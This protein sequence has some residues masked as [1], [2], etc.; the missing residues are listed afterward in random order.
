MRS[1]Y[2]P[3]ILFAVMAVVGACTDP[4]PGLNKFT[5]PGSDAV[6]VIPD[7]G[8]DAGTADAA[9]TDKLSLLG[10]KPTHGPFVGGTTVT[11]R[12]TG[13]K[14]TCKVQIGGKN[15]QVGQTKVLSPLSLAVVS[16]PGIPGPAEVSITC[17]SDKARILN[18]YSYDSV[19]MDPSSGPTAGGTLVQIFGTSTSFAKGMK[20]SLGGKAMT[21]V[22]VAGATALTAKTPAGSAGL[23]DLVVGDGKG[24]SITVKEA[25]TYYVSTNP[26]SGGLGGG[27]IKGTLTVSVLDSMTRA[28]IDSA[29]VLVHTDSQTI[30]TGKTSSTGVLV[31]SKKG[32]TGPVNVTAGK[33]KYESTTIVDLDARDVTIL[34]VQ[35][36]TP[37]SGPGPPPILLSTIKGHI[38]FGGSTGVGTSAWKIVPE[39]KTDEVKRV[40]VYRSIPSMSSKLVTMSY[41]GTIDYDSSTKATA[42]A[43]SIAT[44]PSIQAVYALAGL[45]NKTTKAFVPY[46]MGL[47]RGVVVGPGGTASNVNILVEIPLG[48]TITVAIKDVPASSKVEKVRVGIDLGAEGF[49]VRSDNEVFDATSVPASVAF[50][51]MPNFNYKGLTDA[52]WSVDVALDGGGTMASP[53]LPYVRGTSRSMKAVNDQLTMDK[54]VGPAKLDDPIKGQYLKNNTLKWT[55]TGGAADLIVTRIVLNATPP[56]PVWRIISKGK[57]TTLKLPDPKTSGLNAWTA[58][59]LYIWAQWMVH[60]HPS[61]KFDKFTYDHL[62]SRYW[63]RWS[64]EQSYF[65]LS[66]TP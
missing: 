21:E 34:L 58:G 3:A 44:I 38:I 42:W 52:S 7:T 65:L 26:K 23:V 35:I 66:T 31:F 32:F 43:Y 25:F 41:T 54:F 47:T 14:K 61:Y 45:Y 50:T 4:E 11:L 15:I 33:D 36:A 40:Y 9:A 13:F 6:I 55:P 28:P 17:G 16:P 29:S 1:I 5:V 20:L 63:T 64:Q 48:R 8:P 10:V 57:I 27:V 56:T 51:K 49:I 62:Y 30:F 37:S 12:G 46:A 22:T 19:Y 60:L 18:G 24:K 39:P 2:G 53:Y 59:K